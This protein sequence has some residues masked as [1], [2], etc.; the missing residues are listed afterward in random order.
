MNPLQAAWVA[1]HVPPDRGGDLRH[2]R[3]IANTIVF[4]EHRLALDE[5]MNEHQRR[6]HQA[7]LQAFT[8]ALSELAGDRAGALLE[9]A[10]ARYA[11]RR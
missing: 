5:G 2:L 10:R 11:R 6:H 1:M 7:D 9:D 4:H 8:W 3:R